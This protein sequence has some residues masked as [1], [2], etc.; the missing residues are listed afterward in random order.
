MKTISIIIPLYNEEQNINAVYKEASAVLTTAS[1]VYE[2]IFVNDGST[3]KSLPILKEIADK[4]DKVKVVSHAQNLGQGAAV[5]SGITAAQNQYIS[6]MDCDMQSNPADIVPML[7]LCNQYQI[8]LGWRSKRD[9]SFFKKISSKVGNSLVR[10][11]FKT[12]VEDAGCSLK[13]GPAE[14]FKNIQYFKNY[15]RYLGLILIKTGYTYTYFETH[16]RFRNAGKSKHSVLKFLKVIPEWIA[17]K[18]KYLPK[19]LKQH[20]R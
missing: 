5:S 20:Q 2:L 4:D 10:L 8:V 19:A 17:L 18:Y 3:D 16:H 6:F 11:V 1:L 13:I 7:D 12:R 9:D 15:H 14:A